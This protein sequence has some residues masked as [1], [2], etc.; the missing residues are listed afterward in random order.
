MAGGRN[1]AA[2]GADVVA[3]VADG[4]GWVHDHRA[5]RGGRGANRVGV[6][7][8]VPD[9]GSCFVRSVLLAVACAEQSG[10]GHRVVFGA[11]MDRG[12]PCVADAQ[13][14]LW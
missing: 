12:G 10:D 2:T 6:S 3:D 1:R 8:V 11:D 9:R 7:R 14:Y 4:L 5:V 13:E